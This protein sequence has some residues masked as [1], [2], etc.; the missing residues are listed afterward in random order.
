MNDPERFCDRCAAGVTSNEHHEKCVVSGHAIDGQDVNPID[1]SA[2][3][4]ATN[5]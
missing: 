3:G 1:G 2:L 4:G 5:D